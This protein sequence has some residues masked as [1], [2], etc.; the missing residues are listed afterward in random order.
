MAHNEGEDTSE[1]QEKGA[2]KYLS[3]KHVFGY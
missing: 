3:V 1:G 2:L